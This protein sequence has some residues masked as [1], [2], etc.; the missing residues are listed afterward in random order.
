MEK[1]NTEKIINFLGACLVLGIALSIF[2][3]LM[4]NEM[5]H[6]NRELLIAFVSALFGA[7]AGSVKTI[8]GE[9]ESAQRLRDAEN[10]VR[11]LQEKIAK[12]ENKE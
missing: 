12:L 8:T 5:P 2:F 7:I 9:G 1:N 10:Q 3:M 4:S 11:D 6:S